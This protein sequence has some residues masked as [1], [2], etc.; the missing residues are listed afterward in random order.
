MEWK[1]A[2]EIVSDKG[3]QR[4]KLEFREGI[5]ETREG[6]KQETG[7]DLGGSESISSS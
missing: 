5:Y 6:I 3:Q 2:P 1:P 7:A 4:I